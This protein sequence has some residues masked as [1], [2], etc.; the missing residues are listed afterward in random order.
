MGGKIIYFFLQ[1]MDMMAYFGVKI[2]V[3]TR[4]KKHY[5]TQWHLFFKCI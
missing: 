2:K 1:E 5:F 4:R 3:T